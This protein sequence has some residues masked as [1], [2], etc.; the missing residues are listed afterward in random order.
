[1]CML[2]N[3]GLAHTLARMK[4]IVHQNLV[5]RVCLL[6]ETVA[7]KWVEEDFSTVSPTCFNFKVMFKLQ[8]MI[9]HN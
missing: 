5:E 8:C 1:M 9:L 2:R 4:Q 3:S 7:V 6:L